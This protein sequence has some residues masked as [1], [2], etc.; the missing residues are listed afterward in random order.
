MQNITATSSPCMASLC[1][2]KVG[3]SHGYGLRSDTAGH[4]T[5]PNKLLRTDR[6]VT[7][8]CSDFVQLCIYYNHIYYIY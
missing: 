8:I 1:P 4:C 7:I 3:V 2:E 5:T 6:F